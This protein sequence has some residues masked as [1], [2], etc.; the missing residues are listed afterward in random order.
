MRRAGVLLGGG[1]PP[2]RWVKA[3]PQKARQLRQRGLQLGHLLAGAER[4]DVLPDGSAARSHLDRAAGVGFHDERVAIGQPLGAAV[5]L[6]EDALPVALAVAPGD[7]L[8][9]RVVEGRSPG[10]RG[11]AS[12]RPRPRAARAPRGRPAPR[13]S[14]GERARASSRGT[15][16]E[17]VVREPPPLAAHEPVEETAPAKA[18]SSART[19]SA[20]FNRPTCL[21]A[22]APANA[23]RRAWASGP[24]A[25]GRGRDPSEPFP[26]PATRTRRRADAA[27]S[28]TSPRRRW[29]RCLGNASAMRRRMPPAEDVGELDRLGRLGGPGRRRACARDRAADMAKRSAPMSTRER[30]APGVSRVSGRA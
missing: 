28:G 12:A 15:R 14:G 4:V 17:L 3:P 16:A 18:A 9:E 8:R 22:E 27:R 10:G 13:R 21:R 7:L 5:G 29:S 26:P 20:F 2:S 19:A 23:W 1:G 25:H 30:A 11:A 24:R 6:R